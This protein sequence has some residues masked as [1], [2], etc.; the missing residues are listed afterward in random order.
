MASAPSV[1]EERT[2][3]IHRSALLH[4]LILLLL[5]VYAAPIIGVL[6]T[7]LMNNGE[8]ALR[9]VWHIP[10]NA[11]LANYDDAYYAEKDKHGSYVVSDKEVLKVLAML[12]DMANKCEVK[13]TR[14]HYK[15]HE[16][17]GGFHLVEYTISSMANINALFP[18]DRLHGETV[19]VG[20]MFA[21][22][23]RDDPELPAIDRVFRTRGLPRLPEDLGLDDARFAAAVLAAPATRPGRFTVL[24]H[25]DL[26]SEDVTRRIASFREDFS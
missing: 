16:G 12:T 6:L 17:F 18:N 14:A 4:L 20:T 5:L 2:R 22:Y 15:V 8:I 3:P 25:L 7:S 10:E 9:G 26:G 13:D 21:S 24:E 1:S 19:A 23:L 11:S